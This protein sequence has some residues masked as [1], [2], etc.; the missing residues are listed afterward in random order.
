MRRVCS[1]P[2]LCG[3]IGYRGLR[4]LQL[5]EVLDQAWCPQAV[6]HGATDYLE[7]ITS[8]ADIYRPIQAEIFRAIDD[9]GAARVVDLCSGGGGPV[10]EPALAFRAGQRAPLTVVLT[11]KFPN[12]ELSARLTADPQLKCVNVLRGCR[13]RPG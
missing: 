7:A 1:G 6:R 13:Q 4:R 11:D 10:V 9:C 12:A 8:R 3:E 2:W 5:F